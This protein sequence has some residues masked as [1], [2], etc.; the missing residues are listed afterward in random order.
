M[1]V[2]WRKCEQWRRCCG[3]QEPWLCLSVCVCIYSTG[4]WCTCTLAG[5]AVC[6]L[7]FAREPN[8]SSVNSPRGVRVGAVKLSTSLPRCDAEARRAASNTAAGGLRD[9]SPPAIAPCQ[10]SI[11]R[12]RPARAG[13]ISWRRIND[14]PAL[15]Q[16][17]LFIVIDQKQRAHCW[18]HTESC[19]SSVWRLSSRCLTRQHL[20]L[21]RSSLKRYGFCH[22]QVKCARRRQLSNTTV[23]WVVKAAW[24]FKHHS[25]L[26]GSMSTPNSATRPCDPWA[27]GQPLIGVEEWRGQCPPAPTGSM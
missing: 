14:F 16:N 27:G 1:S 2:R 10:S 7:S 5:C 4:H 18:W 21:L 15:L 17:C 26:Q 11:G 6:V 23:Q 25:H 9:L 24:T 3:R 22:L 8:E 19:T 12:L 13:D 20:K